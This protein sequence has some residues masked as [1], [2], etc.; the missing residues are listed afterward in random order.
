MIL[1]QKEKGKAIDYHSRS[2]QLWNKADEVG[3]GAVEVLKHLSHSAFILQD[4]KIPPSF[5]STHD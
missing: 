4:E 2:V 5:L 1:A 3:C